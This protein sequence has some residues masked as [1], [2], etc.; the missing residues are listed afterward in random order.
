LEAVG[1]ELQ[2]AI[3]VTDVAARYGGDEFVAILVRTTGQAARR[4]GEAVRLAVE[5]VGTALGFDPGEV[6]V[7]VGVAGYQPDQPSTDLLEQADRAL[8][9]AK[10]AGGNAVA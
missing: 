5:A 2:R 3:R 4:V 1:Q 9:R 10:A 8:Y 7:S 6:T